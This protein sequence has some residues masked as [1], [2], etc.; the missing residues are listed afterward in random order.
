ME[1][2]TQEAISWGKNNLKPKSKPGLRHFY[3]DTNYYLLGLIIKNIT[4]KPFYR[5]MHELI[6]EPL[7]MKYAYMHGFTT[8][9]TPSKHPIAKPYLDNI[10]GF[11]IKCLP[12]IDHAG[13]SVIA[14]VD[15]L[16][17]FMRALVE[18]RLTSKDTLNTMPNDSYKMRFPG[19]GFDYGYGIWKIKAIPLFIP[20]GFDCWGG[21]EITGAFMFFH[22]ET[23]S[24][25]IGTFN[26]SSYKT[27]AIRF[28]LSKVINEL[29]KAK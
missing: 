28:M 7:G 1:I 12:E 19:L 8:P 26:D 25:I 16:L 17:L 24:Y 14:P 5:V 27:R 2:T 11:S 4:G 21:V 22:P 15:D 6:F 10:D 13:G 18:N 3:T 23:D 9:A 20:K 29:L